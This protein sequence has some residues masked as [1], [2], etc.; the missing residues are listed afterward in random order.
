MLTLNS[1]NNGS[2]L[3]RLKPEVGWNDSGNIYKRPVKFLSFLST[4]I[5]AGNEKH[6]G[7]FNVASMQWN[8]WPL[9]W[10]TF[11]SP[12]VKHVHMH[13]SSTPAEQSPISVLFH[14]V[15]VP[16]TVVRFICHIKNHIQA[17]K[18][19][20]CKQMTWSISIFA[21]LVDRLRDLSSR[22]VKS[23]MLLPCTPFK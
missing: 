23:V 11:I 22:A 16:Q 3:D 15:F 4:D 2:R 1:R 8:A 14:F 12:S 21:Q 20:K 13:C 6:P 10:W 17:K 7:L 19:R 5:T 9:T 18:N